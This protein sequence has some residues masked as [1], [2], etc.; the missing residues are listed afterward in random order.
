M[1]RSR[2]LGNKAEEPRFVVDTMLGHVARWLRFLG[3]DAEYIPKE[4]SD[5]EVVERALSEGRILVTRDHDL[6]R[7]R[8]LKGRYVLVRSEDALKAVG[9][10]LD[11]LGLKPEARPFT[12]CPECNVPIEE[13]DRDCVS[14]LVPIKVR[15]TQKAFSRCPRCGRVF[16]RG[17]HWEQMRERIAGVLGVGREE[18]DSGEVDLSALGRLGGEGGMAHKWRYDEVPEEEVEGA[19]GVKV[20]WLLD[21]SR[22]ARNFAMR[23][24]EVEP[25]GCT[26]HHSHPYEHEVFVLEGRGIVKVGEEEFEVG[27]WDV[28]FVPPNTPHCF[29]CKGVG[30]FKFICVVPLKKGGR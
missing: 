18:V 29:K 28:V 13:V 5:S 3:F 27:P 16:W 26:P 23:L 25:G 8:A 15:V 11:A 24:F 14:P 1:G 30:A 6:V 10:V 21:E 2:G 12:R 19:V 7:R 17:K 4:A 22:G 9:E 20:R